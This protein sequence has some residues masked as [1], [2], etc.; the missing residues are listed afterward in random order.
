MKNFDYY[1]YQNI[2]FTQTSEKYYSKWYEMNRRCYEEYLL[3][4]SQLSSRF[5]KWYESWGIHDSI[6]KNVSAQHDKHGKWSVVIVLEKQCNSGNRRWFLSY[7]DVSAFSVCRKHI[8][9]SSFCQE[10]YLYDEFYRSEKDQTRI[11][12]EFFTSEETFFYI[13]FQK[14]TCTIKKTE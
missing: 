10:V 8:S 13:E 11:V 7:K 14:L 6:V 12:H 5:T 3:C 4:K 2:D 1:L 9:S